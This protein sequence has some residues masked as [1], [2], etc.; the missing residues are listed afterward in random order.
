MYTVITSEERKEVNCVE[1]VNL[2]FA[3]LSICLKKK[4]MTKDVL[5]DVLSSR[6]KTTASHAIYR[7]KN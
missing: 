7:T 3:M 1:S 2:I 6:E 4:K 5:L